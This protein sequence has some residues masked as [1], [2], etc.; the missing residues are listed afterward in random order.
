MQTAVMQTAS[1]ITD[2][3]MWNCKR[4]AHASTETSLTAKAAAGRAA[5]GGS[6]PKTIRT[7]EGRDGARH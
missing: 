3:P 4:E 6:F 7:Q 5:H 1:C 2:L